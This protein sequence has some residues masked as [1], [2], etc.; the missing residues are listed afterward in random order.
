[1]ISAI[2]EAIG[3]TITAFA[4]NLASAFSSI[5]SMFWTEGN[6]TTGGSLTTLGI[7]T[8]ITAGVA[9]VVFAFQFIYRLIRRA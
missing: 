3:Q 8:L 5:T 2:F 7:A 4:Q 9:L 1:M 6:G